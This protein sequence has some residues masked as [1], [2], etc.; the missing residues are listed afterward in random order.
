MHL[1]RILLPLHDNDKQ[2][3]AVEQFDTVRTELTRRF[4]GVTAFLRAP[5]HALW[6][7]EREINRDDIVMFEIIT[8]SLEN[9]WWRDYRIH[10]QQVFKQEEVLVW[11]TSVEKL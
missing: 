2:A 8:K 9:E 1:I 4:G 5:A 10:L 11:A 3:F 7:G 6:D